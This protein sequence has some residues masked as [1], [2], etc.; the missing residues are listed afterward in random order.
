MSFN[1]AEVELLGSSA[2]LRGLPAADL[3]V[4]LRAGRAHALPDGAFFFLEADPAE[5]AFIL[6]HGKVKL[7]QVTEVGQQVILGYII[8]GRVFGVISVI[9]NMVYPVS[10][11]AVGECRALWW[12]QSTLNRLMDA[13]PRIGL[14]AMRIMAGQIRE[15]Q[16][17]IR[18]LSTKRVEQRIARAVLRLARQS[19]RKTEAGIL[20]DL[21]LTR[22]DL[23]EMTGTTLYTVSRVLNDWEAQGLV[24]SQRQR[25]V[26]CSAH[27][28]VDIGEDLPTLMEDEGKILGDAL[29]ESGQR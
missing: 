11:Q 21:P 18:D 17:T 8:P 24:Q 27:G 25:V 19:G 14:N 5:K 7:G 13:S 26:I 23:A 2:L 12:D 3:Q 6:L 15:F 4:V 10:A 16:N 29:E 9:Q 1:Q 22:Q 28:L 20:I